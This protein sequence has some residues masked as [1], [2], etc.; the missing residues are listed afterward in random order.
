[1]VDLTGSEPRILREGAVRAPDA[2]ARVGA[3]LV[4]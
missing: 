4:E 1:V 3:V 2:L